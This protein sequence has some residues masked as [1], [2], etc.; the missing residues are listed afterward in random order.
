MCS[1]SII[2]DYA[3]NFNLLRG[4]FK[5]KI[6]LTYNRCKSLTM[7][8]NY[9]SKNIS[10]RLIYILEISNN[11]YSGWKLWSLLYGT[12]KEGGDSQEKRGPGGN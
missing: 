3:K 9:N 4:G 2:Q 10:W 7:A 12:E 1:K 5:K 11:F 8:K 6:S